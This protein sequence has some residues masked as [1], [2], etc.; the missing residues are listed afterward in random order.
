M[1]ALV[2]AIHVAAKTTH[3]L[4]TNTSKKSEEIEIEIIHRGDSC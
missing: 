2:A 4:V 1:I 3:I